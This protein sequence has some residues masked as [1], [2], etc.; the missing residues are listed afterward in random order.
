MRKKSISLAL[1]ISILL[2]FQAALFAAPAPLENPGTPVWRLDA[3]NVSTLPENFR[4]S[5]DQFKDK[6]IK[7]DLPSREGMFSL[8]ISGSAMFSANQLDKLI[9]EIRTVHEGP[10][11]IMDL[12]QESHGFVNGIGVSSY[13]DRN[14]INVGK[15]VAQVE[16][17]EKAWLRDSLKAP[18]EIVD[19]DDDKKISETKKI[20]VETALTEKELITSRKIN[21]F[22]IQATDHSSFTDSQVDDFVKFYKKELP[23]DAWLHFHCF[24]GEGRTTQLMVMYDILRNG[25]KVS[26]QDIVNRQYLIGGNDAMKVTA[27]KAKDAY[28]IPLYK[29]KAQML[30]D[31]YQYVTT[32]PDDLPLTFTKWK[33]AQRNDGKAVTDKPAKDKSAKEKKE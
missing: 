8:K 25:K 19:L 7:G 9:A 4:T 31:F 30:Q 27:S 22:H 16:K 20:Q 17:D 21:Y 5:F 6:K 10:I 28:K 14:W 3:K 18:I 2:I 32:S 1:V 23:Q 33:K 13:V 15:S 11:V 24:A 29:E 12:R 26:F